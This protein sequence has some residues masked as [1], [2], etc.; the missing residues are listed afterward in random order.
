MVFEPVSEQVTAKEETNLRDYPSQGEDSTVIMKLHNGEVAERIGISDTGWS[1]LQ[2]NGNVCYAVSNFLTSD[3]D[4]VPASTE[5]T[6]ST[7]PAYPDGTNAFFKP[8]QDKVTA[9]K[10]VN[11]RSM[12][13]VLNPECEILGTLHSGEVLLRVGICDNGWSKLVYEDWVVYA[14][15]DYLT[16][17]GTSGDIG[18][19]LP[20]DEGIQTRFYACDDE[21]TAKIEVNLRTK[22]SATDED[23]VVAYTVKNGT[24]VHRNGINEDAGWSRVEYQGQILYCV[25]R[26]LEP[27]TE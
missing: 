6:E 24:P 22:P 18:E 2:F 27:Y 16:A 11:L 19:L 20:P 13:S 15:S 10:E 26:L 12:P 25:S 7:A 21:V 4:Y 5:S 8:V 3:L 17:N 1:K 14:L 23:A 9:K